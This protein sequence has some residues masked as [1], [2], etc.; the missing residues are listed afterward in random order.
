M[1]QHQFFKLLC[2]L[3]FSLF[4]Y[5]WYGEKNDMKKY[6]LIKIYLP[7]IPRKWTWSFCPLKVYVPSCAANLALLSVLVR[8]SKQR[9][10]CI[11]GQPWVKKNWK[12]FSW[13]PRAIA[14]PLWIWREETMCR[15]GQYPALTTEVEAKSKSRRIG[16]PRR[17]WKPLNGASTLT[18]RGCTTIWFLLRI[19]TRWQLSMNRD[20]LKKLTEITAMLMGITANLL[21]GGRE[22]QGTE[23]RFSSLSTILAEQNTCNLT[24]R[25]SWM[26]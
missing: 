22:R 14:R 2:I 1:S 19:C 15:S 8:F 24:G 12:H 25:G 7:H 5:V 13:I 4:F 11:K 23:I 3:F 10:D 21:L 20:L 18:I 9:R 6:T 26:V 16:Y 17:T